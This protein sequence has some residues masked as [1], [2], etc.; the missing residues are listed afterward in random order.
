MQV[1]TAS[2]S[3]DTKSRMLSQVN[4]ASVKGTISNQAYKDMPRK[5]NKR[6]NDISLT[7]KK[8][9]KPRLK[10]PGTLFRPTAKM[11]KPE[12]SSGLK[13]NALSQHKSTEQQPIARKVFTSRASC[14]EK[15]SHI[16]YLSV[17]RAATLL[18]NGKYQAREN[19]GYVG[20][21]EHVNEV[22]YSARFDEN[23]DSLTHLSKNGKYQAENTG[24]DGDS[25]RVNE[26]GDS[27]RFEE[28]FDKSNSGYIEVTKYGGEGSSN[29]DIKV[30]ECGGEDSIS[31]HSGPQTEQ[32]TN[33]SD[34][35]QSVPEC[36][37]AEANLISVL[38]IQVL[39]IKRKRKTDCSFDLR[40]AMY[41]KRKKQRSNIYGE[42]NFKATPMP[43]LYREPDD[44][45]EKTKIRGNLDLSHS[46]DLRMKLYV[47]RGDLLSH[48]TGI[49]KRLRNTPSQNGADSQASYDGPENTDYKGD[50]EH[51][52]EIGHSAHFVEN[53]D[54]AATLLENGKYQASE[55]EGYAG[56][57]E[58]V[59]EVGH[60]ACFD[61]NH[62]RSTHLSKNGKYQ[63][64]NTGYDGDFE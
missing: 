41:R 37:E 56:H 12:V 48:T 25:E 22:G 8:R 30:T 35:L 52:N 29:G 32:D 7:Q 4:I 47:G 3:R 54:R 23:Y 5:P 43:S 14:T 44:R 50:F 55:N 58:L 36:L 33:S 61:E 38:E 62:D 46:V 64:K 19:E 18:E 51:V 63:A 49:L 57:L 11:P 15:A 21:F 59:N 31:C 6:H 45:S 34:V 16:L 9:E 53:H 10:S 17:N 2:Q 40:C 39:M 27:A 60:S 13:A 24:Y 20:H 28:S 42:I 26:V 1:R